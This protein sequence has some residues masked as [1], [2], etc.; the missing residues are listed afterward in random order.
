MEAITAIRTRRSV[1]RLAEPAPDAAALHD[2][3]AAAVAAPDH[4]QLQPWRFVVFTG[5]GRTRLGEVFAAAHEAREPGLDPGVRD[6]TAG[7]P[8]RAPMVV[9]VICQP[10]SAEDAWN[11]KSIPVWEQEAAVAAAT[12][13]LCLAAHAQGYGA[14]WRT[15]WFGD[16]PEVR[17]ALA[18]GPEDRVIGWVY[19]GTVPPTFNPAPKRPANPESLVTTWQ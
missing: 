18:L 19:L 2:L 13:N 12:Q 10:V 17:Q 6:Q 3:L 8:L 11:G 5:E 14:M 9:A 4:G 15:G 1:P 16:A 7:K